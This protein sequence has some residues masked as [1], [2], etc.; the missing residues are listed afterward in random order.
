M[1]TG[2]TC[3]RVN[4]ATWAF[5]ESGEAEDAED[6]GDAAGARGAGVGARGAVPRARRGEGVFDG[7]VVPRADD[8]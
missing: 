5:R 1:Q 3:R 2:V 4:T 6:A 7:S 8:R